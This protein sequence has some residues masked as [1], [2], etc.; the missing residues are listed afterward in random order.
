MNIKRVYIH[1][2]I[3]DAFLAAM[4]DFVSN[5]LKPGPAS[6]STTFVGPLQNAM[7]YDK[8]KELYQHAEAEKWKIALGGLKEKKEGQGFILP[9]TIVDNPADDSRIVVEEPFGPILPTLRWT[10]EAD[11]IRRANDTEAGLG[12]SVWSA[13]VERATQMADQLEAGSVWVNCHF[14]VGPQLP[15]GGHKASGVGMEWGSVGL[16]GWCNPQSLWTKTLL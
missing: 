2:K 10:D 13:N 9:P 14:E 15:F 1:D 3:Y 16:K 6:D 12:A 4:V 11:V 5:N 7:Q 8:V